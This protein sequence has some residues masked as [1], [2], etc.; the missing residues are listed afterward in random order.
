MTPGQVV[1]TVSE[2]EEFLRISKTK[3]Y[4]LS[5]DAAVPR[6]PF[7]RVGGQRRYVMSDILLYLDSQKH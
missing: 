3:L 4:R 6:L 1:L 7:R 5:S 2:T